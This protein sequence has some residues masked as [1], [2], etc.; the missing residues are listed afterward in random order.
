MHRF[1]G[2]HPLGFALGFCVA[3]LGLAALLRLTL[4]LAGVDS[5]DTIA[6]CLDIALGLAATLLLTGLGWW[7][8]AGF[9]QPREWRQLH[10]LWFPLV[11]TALPFLGGVE[12][13]ALR[14]L[15]LLVAGTLVGVW[16]EE[17][18]F[19]GLLWRALLSGGPWRATVTTA[20]LF[21]AIHLGIVVLGGPLEAAVPLVI[22]ATCAGLMYGAIRTRTRSI[23]P[24]LL[25]H[26][27]WNLVN[28]I[29]TAETSDML[30]LVMN[31]AVTFGFAGYGLLLLRR[32]GTV[33]TRELAPHGAPETQAQEGGA[34]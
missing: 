2:R 18:L 32:G 9:N 28:Q 21:G 4:G 30:L 26:A 1:I 7:C 3:Q 14:S 19:R 31:L 13:P 17:A 27:V 6:T 15:P 33:A 5:P 8:E 20:L 23:W 11:I 29:T 24:V 22:S 10:L 25:L 12:L 16:Q 34:G